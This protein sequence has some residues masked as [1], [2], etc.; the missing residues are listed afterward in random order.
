VLTNKEKCCMFLVACVATV[1]IYAEAGPVSILWTADCASDYPIQD[2]NDRNLKG[3]MDVPDTVTMCGH[4]PFD[5]VYL[6]WDRDVDGV[7]IFNCAREL[8][9]DT[10]VDSSFIGTGILCA[11]CSTGGFS[12]SKDWAV[13]GGDYDTFY[14]IALND[15]T[16]SLATYFG[17]TLQHSP[18]VWAVHKDSVNYELHCTANTTWYAG[19]PFDEYA[20]FN[21][22]SIASGGVEPGAKKVGLE[23]IAASVPS[24]KV[25]WTSIT[26]DNGP[27]A[28]CTND[29]ADVDSVK[30]YRE[31]TGAGF[32]PGDDLLIGEAEWGPGPPDGGSATVTFFSPETLQFDSSY[33]YIAFDISPGA[34]RENC[35]AACVQDSS[36]IGISQFC[37]DGNFPFCSDDVGLPVEISRFEAFP[38]DELILLEWTTQSEIDNKGFYVYRAFSLEGEFSRVDDELIPGAGNSYMPIDYEYIDRGLKNGT[39]YFYKLVS[40]TF[41]NALS[42]FEEVVSGTPSKDH[43]RVN[44]GS[45]LLGLSPNP[46]SSASQIT[47]MVHKDSEVRLNVYD[48]S[49]RLVRTLVN[50]YRNSGMHTVEWDGQSDTR[51]RVASGLYFCRLESA[52]SVSVMKMVRVD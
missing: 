51:T 3:A 12:Q 8:S 21:G 4:G 48:S 25:L 35:V 47:F 40:I 49:G 33:Y 41:G 34:T 10:V 26:V 46:S 42:T 39:E 37:R 23:R 9:G 31:V 43:W 24:G 20:V 52:G 17:T 19:R 2:E 13:Q 30:I 6:V 15:T 27:S 22:S 5:L 38:G 14:V 16:L 11:S 50:A 28:G 18:S 44:A 1:L 45:G 7:E 36:Y 29:S 32:D